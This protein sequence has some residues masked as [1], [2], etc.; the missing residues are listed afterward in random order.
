MS[1]GKMQTSP[2]LGWRMDF[3]HVSMLILLASLLV[4]S[5]A[6]IAEVALGLSDGRPDNAFGEIE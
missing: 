6:R 3:I 2:A 5:L 4:F 1:I